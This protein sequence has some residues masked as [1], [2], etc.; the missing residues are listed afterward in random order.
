MFVGSLGSI[1]EDGTVPTIVRWRTSFNA[2]NELHS[3]RDIGPA[4]LLEDDSVVDI[5]MMMTWYTG[6]QYAYV[7]LNCFKMFIVAVIIEIIFMI[8]I[9][10]K[11]HCWSDPTERHIECVSDIHPLVTSRDVN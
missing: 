10:L 1:T 7:R 4:V 11:T 2:T 6:L 3:L 5:M 9:L 8:D